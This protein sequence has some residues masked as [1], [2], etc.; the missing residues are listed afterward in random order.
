M[1][2]HDDP[3]FAVRPG[4]LAAPVAI[5]LAAELRVAMLDHLRAA[6]PCEGC[7]LLAAAPADGGAVRAVRFYPGT[8]VD[9]ST[10]R[11]TMDPVE[12]FAAFRDMRAQ[13]WHLAAIV[14]SHPATPA[15]PSPTDLREAFYPEA[16]MVI[17]SFAA[18]P[19]AMRAWR[20]WPPSLGPRPT[21]VEVPIV[22]GPTSSPR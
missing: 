4:E 1:P 10:I 21:P 9:A 8:N 5:A 18:V 19:P 15:S 16:V 22:L 3:T 14:H 17:V 13:G 6:L 2:E 12:V 20:V 11:Y 7:G